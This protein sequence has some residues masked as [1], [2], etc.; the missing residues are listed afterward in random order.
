MTTNKSLKFYIYKM[1]VDSG[2]APCVFRGTLSLAICKPAIRSSCTVGNWIFGFGSKKKC[3][4][5]IYIAE[6]RSKI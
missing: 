3:E 1:T 5:L 2:G 6:I 4:K